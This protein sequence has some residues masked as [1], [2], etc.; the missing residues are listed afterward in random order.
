[1]P[2]AL[3][4]KQPRRTSTI[5]WPLPDSVSVPC[6][7]RCRQWTSA[8]VRPSR[9]SSRRA[10][11]TP[12]SLP[13][14]AR[15]SKTPPGPGAMVGAVRVLPIL[16]TGQAMASMDASILVVA[17][18]SLRADL[19]ASEAQ[20]QLV[21][22]T[23]TLAFAALVVA[24]ARLGDV[25]GPRRVFLLGLA[26]FTMASLAGGL[27]PTATDVIVA[28]SV[29]G[30]AGALM[31]P[32]VLTIIQREYHGEAR[33]RA[34]GAYSLILAVG[35]AAGQVA[36][37]LLVSAH[38]LHGAW[39]PALLLN[40]P[41]GA[42]LLVAARRGLPPMP[43]TGRRTVDGGGAGLLA[44]TMLMLVLAVDPRP[45]GGAGPG[46]AS[47]PGCRGGV[48]DVLRGVGA[49]SSHGQ[50]AMPLFDLELLR[51][52]GV[53]AAA[54]RGPADHGSLRGIP[55]LPD[56]VPPGRPELL[57]GACRLHSRRVCGGLRGGKPHVAPSAGERIRRTLPTVGPL[58]MASALRWSACWRRKAIGPLRPCRFCCW[59][60][61]A[62][63]AV[64]H[65]SQTDSPRRSQPGAI[66]GPERPAAHRE[67]HR[68][69]SGHG[70]RP[71]YLPR[72]SA[73]RVRLCAGE[74]NPCPRG[75]A[76][77]HRSVR[78]VGHDGSADSRR[79]ALMPGG[80]SRP[81]RCRCGCGRGWLTTAR[82]PP[83]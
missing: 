15:M 36:G 16:L 45:T 8:T 25:F 77:G 65:R 5:V 76:A 35:V 59:R 44:A 26:G 33:A 78:L 54:L 2:S 49:T 9:R 4:R 68:H 19:H 73:V 30:A 56:L 14:C 66:A 12:G 34:I 53:A 41:I 48:R 13:K 63:P 21:V 71:G 7:A 39:R 27:A 81:D 1:M 40:A 23:Y 3:R 17:A 28:R 67:P 57:T 70:E 55:A 79:A 20:L 60:V 24:G 82:H 18:P 37:G 72:C 6:P 10:W 50:T 75:S 29:Q 52:P 64:S 47:V 46:G 74:D 83:G 51:V 32:Q 58:V 22:V 31:T 43:A 11:S 38:L 42:A 62:T 80:T 61:P 69:G